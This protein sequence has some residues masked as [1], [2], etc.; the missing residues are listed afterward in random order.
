MKGVV[1]SITVLLMSIFLTLTSYAEECYKFLYVIDGDTIKILFNGKR[2][3]VRLLGIDTP[4]SRKN[5]RAYYQARKNHLDVETIVK[6]GKEARKHL[7]ELLAD[8]EEVCLVYD[9]N[10][11]QTKHRDRYGRILAYVFTPDGEFINKAMLEDG[12]AY[13][14]TQYPLE[15]EYEEEL[16]EAFKYAVENQRGLWEDSRE[17]T[18]IGEDFTCGEKKYCF[19]MNSCEEAMFYFKVCGLTRLDGDGDGIPCE[20]L[21]RY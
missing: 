7:K 14:L 9:E 2:T 17:E 3:S 13:L 10:N 5:R 21:C 16:R 4:E 11:A 19:Q 18:P 12:Y 6:L 15:P 8:Y 20:R 1:R